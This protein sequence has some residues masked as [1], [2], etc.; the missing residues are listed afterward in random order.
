MGADYS[1][2]DWTEKDAEFE[3]R[4]AQYGGTYSNLNPYY[5]KYLSDTV[6]DFR[7]EHHAVQAFESTGNVLATCPVCGLGQFRET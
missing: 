5:R 7:L 2:V 3:K 1:T 4:L 6:P